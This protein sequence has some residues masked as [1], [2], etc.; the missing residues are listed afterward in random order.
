MLKRLRAHLAQHVVGYIALFIVLGGTAVALPGKKSIDKNDLKRNVVKT[1]NIKNHAVTKRKLAKNAV[2]PAQVSGLVEG[3]GQ[4]LSRSASAGQVGFLPNP[5]VLADIPGFGQI[6]FLYC[7]VAPARQMRVR[8]LSD[9]NAANFFYSDEV[10]WGGVPP[11]TGQ[12]QGS[13]TG[14]GTL[15]GGGGEPLLTS[16]TANGFTLGLSAK[17]DFQIWRGDGA[18]TTGAHTIVSGVNSLDN[19]CHVTAQTIIQR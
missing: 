18:N 5:A 10:R 13:D 4:L 2:G 16:F 1:K 7:G 6:Q 15:G 14:G 19:Q 12:Q 3:N 9:D 17:W 11:G 8:V